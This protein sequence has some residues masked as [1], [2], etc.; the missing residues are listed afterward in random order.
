MIRYFLG[1]DVGAT[2]THVLVSDE[3]GQAC[4]FGQS[5]PGNHE[6]VGYDGLHEALRA[7]TD[8]ALAMA[9][10]SKDQIA[11]AGFGVAGL[12]WPSEKEPTLRAIGELSLNTPIEAVNDALIG[13]LAGSTEGW[14]IAVVS[15]TGCNCRGWDRT[16]RR[17]GQV[18]G[19]SWTMGEAGGG[20]ELVSQAVRAIAYEWTQRGPATQLTPAFVGYFGARDVIDFLQGVTED[21]IRLSPAAAPLVF[22]IA[23]AGDAVAAGLIG[24]IGR[25]LGEMSNAVTRQLGFE[26][27]TF[28]V[29][30]VGSLFDGGALLIEPMRATIHAFAPGARLARLTAPPV[31]GAVL[32]GME[33]AGITL[34]AE[35]RETLN[36][37]ATDIRHAVL[38]SRR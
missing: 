5:G 33:Q 14:G 16:R 37:S 8:Q 38:A 31:V 34:S 18:T 30:L 22:E 24:W 11:G 15:G 27:E 6:T 9:G 32:L 21:R 2:K 29:V 26:S 7:A 35:A 13:L 10:V 20:M 25:E 28:E 3:N 4:G 1:A 12:D 36:Q 19:G 23:G 17:Q